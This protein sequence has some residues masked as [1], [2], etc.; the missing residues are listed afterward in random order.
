MLG[1]MGCVGEDG[2]LAAAEGSVAG[3][4][5]GADGVSAGGGGGGT[6]GLICCARERTRPC[7]QEYSQKAMYA[8]RFMWRAD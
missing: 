3:V 2:G 1:S 5:A 6:L 4:V 7:E 8:G